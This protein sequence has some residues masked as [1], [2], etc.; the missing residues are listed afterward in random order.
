MEAEDGEGREGEEGEEEDGS[1]ETLPAAN[2][3]LNRNRV[4]AELVHHHLHVLGS[5]S[6]TDSTPH[7]QSS[8]PFRH[9]K[10]VMLKRP[11]GQPTFQECERDQRCR[12][13]PINIRLIF[14]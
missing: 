4:A 14:T 8:P 3:Q 11:D 6:P 10:S 1:L 13:H 12:N 7:P 9:T 2:G 5:R